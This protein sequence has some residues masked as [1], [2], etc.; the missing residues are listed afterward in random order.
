MKSKQL[1]T[2]P[3]GKQNLDIACHVQATDRGGVDEV[4]CIQNVFGRLCSVVKVKETFHLP[5]IE[6]QGF[7]VL[8]GSLYSKM[9]AIWALQMFREYANYQLRTDN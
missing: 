3:G 4:T 9:D 5:G 2:S 6:F 1:S 8:Q 7:L